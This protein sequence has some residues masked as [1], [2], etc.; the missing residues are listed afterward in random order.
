ML[1]RRSTNTRTSA[2]SARVT[3][4]L[5]VTL[6]LIR[7]TYAGD[8]GNGEPW[9]TTLERTHPLVGQVWDVAAAEFLDTQTLV[10]RL[11]HGQFVVLGEKHD[12]PDHHRLQAWLL[13]ALIKAGRR[14]AVGFEMFDT[15]DA[16]AIACHLAASPTDA[17]GL[18]EAVD[19]NQ[20]GW[21]DWAM[22]QPIAEV[23]LAKQLPIV[24]TNFP[25]TLTHT[26]MQGGT[27][28]LD[29]GLVQRLD[30]S[31]PLAPEIYA[32]MAHEIRDSH[33]GHAPEAML[34]AMITVQRARDA[35][36][37]NSL[38]A[39]HQQDGAVLIAGA[40][41]GRNDRGVPAHLARLRP[42]AKVI[43]VAFL[44]VQHGRLEPTAYA[45]EGEQRERGALPF[46]YVWFTPRVD[47]VDPCEKFRHQLEHMQRKHKKDKL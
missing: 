38:V 29:T 32:Q 47:N 4:F 18:A 28:A 31:R 43:S 13:D 40:L 34:E 26:L 30:L 8:A 12:N 24:A 21:P 39:A 23:A 7:L 2:I 11:V 22:Y 25:A 10:T 9:Q 6:V 36:M 33:C 5:V 17:V 15:D 27:T 20:S 3:V 41:H 14:P 19:W 16:P 42:Y 46:D 45:S 1:Y 37:A 35:Q 44:E